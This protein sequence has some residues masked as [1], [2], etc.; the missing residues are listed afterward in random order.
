MGLLTLE[1]VLATSTQ[2]GLELSER[3]F[4]YYVVLGLLPKP[5]KKPGEDARV[6]FY[7]LAI[8]DRLQE[9]RSLQEQ[10]FSL[11]QIKK[12]V[13]ELPA[14]AAHL[15]LVDLL[16]QGKVKPC[17]F[18]ELE[19]LRT[20]L[21]QSS[22]SGPVEEARQWLGQTLDELIESG[23]AFATDSQPATWKRIEAAQERLFQVEKLLL[24]YR[25]LRNP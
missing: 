21:R 15:P 19:A 23:R 10:G 16:R 14:P 17:H 6:H 24:S 1:E 13:E 3:T 18:E 9:I 7:P 2:R 4:R 12:Y 20:D 22:A 5:L 8:L 25:E 11:K